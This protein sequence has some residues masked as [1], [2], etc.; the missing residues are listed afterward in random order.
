MYE[1]FFSKKAELKA[2]DGA[3]VQP[4]AGRPSYA[5]RLKELADVESAAAVL[6]E[7]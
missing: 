5:V 4:A 7:L 2:A 1:D 6:Q 3:F